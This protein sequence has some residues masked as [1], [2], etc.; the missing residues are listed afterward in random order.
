MT[1]SVG[2]NWS[3]AFL[4]NDLLVLVD[5]AETFGL[6]EEIDLSELR[7]DVFADLGVLSL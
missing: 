5:D 4:M 2:R 7:R 1:S 6:F 3:K